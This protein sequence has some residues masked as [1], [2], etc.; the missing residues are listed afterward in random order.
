MQSEDRIERPCRHFFLRR[1]RQASQPLAPTQFYT[2]Y[3]AH[4]FLNIPGPADI[5]RKFQQLRVRAK[6]SFPK[7]RNFFVPSK[8]FFQ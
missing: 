7:I 1:H 6:M 8:Q 2:P 4:K 3:V 5:A